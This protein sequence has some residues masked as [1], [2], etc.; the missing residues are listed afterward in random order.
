[1]RPLTRG[2]PQQARRPTFEP[3]GEAGEEDGLMKALV[4]P[5]ECGFDVVLF[6]APFVVAPSLRPVPRKVK[7]RTGRP[8]EVKAFMT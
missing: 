5:V 7:R 3:E 6:A 2:S 8:K 1:M 4:E